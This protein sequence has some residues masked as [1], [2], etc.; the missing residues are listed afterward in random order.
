MNE[1]PGTEG[2]V[3]VGHQAHTKKDEGEGSVLAYVTELEF[4]KQRS[5]SSFCCL[6]SV[7]L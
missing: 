1:M 7:K 4:R 2:K 5:R 6:Q 3:H